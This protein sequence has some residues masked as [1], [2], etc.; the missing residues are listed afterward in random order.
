M[1]LN[2]AERLNARVK[3]HVRQCGHYRDGQLCRPFTGRTLALGFQ[4]KG[5]VRRSGRIVRLRPRRSSGR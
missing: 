5:S 1:W 4:S 3:L 2:Q